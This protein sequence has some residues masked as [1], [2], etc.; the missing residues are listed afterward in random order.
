MNCEKC[1][2]DLYRALVERYPKQQFYFEEKIPELPPLDKIT[3]PIEK[4]KEFNANLSEIMEFAAWVCGVKPEKF[5]RLDMMKF[6]NDKLSGTVN[7]T[8]E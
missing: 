1:G 6:V 8:N 2:R 3:I 7:E 4:V 5:C